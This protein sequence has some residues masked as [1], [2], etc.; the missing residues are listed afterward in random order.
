MP[1]PAAGPADLKYA[2]SHEWVRDHG[3]GTVTVGITAYAQDHLGELVYVELPAVGRKLAA[4]E[5]CA[6]VESTKAASDVYSPVAGEVLAVNTA[7]SDAPQTVNDAPFEAGWLF[8]MRLSDTGGL[9]KLLD[10]KAYGDLV[11]EQS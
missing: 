3:D 10:A 1:N 11:A 9:A 4:A 8:K 5:A 7:L 2:Q 6:V